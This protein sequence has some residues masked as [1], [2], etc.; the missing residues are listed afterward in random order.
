[1]RDD[2]DADAAA[3]N[4]EVLWRAADRD[5]HLRR[6]IPSAM[7]TVGAGLALGGLLL[8]A[9][10]H[11]AAA[12]VMGCLLLVALPVGVHWVRDSRA[13]VEVHVVL[14]ERTALRLRKAVG[15]TVEIPAAS[16]SRV[17]LVVTPFQ[18]P[19]SPGAGTAVLHLHIRQGR[20]FRCRFTGMDDRGHARFQEAW[21]RVCPAASFTRAARTWPLP[22][23][24]YG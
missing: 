1:M 15:R 3:A 5:A 10:E 8:A 24:D 11:V 23:G 2:D 17:H 6:R 19:D 16:V 4:G 12:V 13:V 20:R 18:E 14:G 7:V 22:S 9:D 21:S